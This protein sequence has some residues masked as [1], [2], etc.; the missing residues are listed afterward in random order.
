[1]GEGSPVRA[2]ASRTH[3]PAPPPPP[4][5]GGSE[6]PRAARAHEARAR[7]LPVAS[8]SSR[9][10]RS[11]PASLIQS[12]ARASS[13]PPLPPRS[14]HGRPFLGKPSLLLLPLG[15]TRRGLSVVSKPSLPHPAPGPVFPNR[16]EASGRASGLR[17]NE[18]L[19]AGRAAAGAAAARAWSALGF[20]AISDFT[21][22]SVA[23]C[24]GFLQCGPA[25]YMECLR[26]NYGLYHST[27]RIP[28]P[29]GTKRKQCSDS[30]KLG[31]PAVAG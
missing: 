2:H 21:D 6:L 14:C 15:P 25:F 7:A 19:G 12:R 3:L 5:G 26:S 17:A 9:P 31:I 23:E 11:V 29:T 1:M 13:Q 20:V 27:D 28:L 10:A 24:R 18:R 22:S 16:G 8:S 4:P 30:K